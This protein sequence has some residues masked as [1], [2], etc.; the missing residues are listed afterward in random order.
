[1]QWHAWC[2]W[3]PVLCLHSGATLSQLLVLVVS[4][5]SN[6]DC[7]GLLM[8]WHLS[9]Q[10]LSHLGGVCAREFLFLRRSNVDMHLFS[11]VWLSVYSYLSDVCMSVRSCFSDVWVSVCSILS[12]VFVI[13]SVAFYCGDVVG[14]CALRMWV[15]SYF[16]TYVWLSVGSC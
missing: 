13:V 15:C 9:E 2:W 8:M 1:M 5:E 14:E 10:S 7:S 6:I 12:D 16:L 11:F 3:W 4:S